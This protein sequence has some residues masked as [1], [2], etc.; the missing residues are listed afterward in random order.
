MKI[1]NSD[2]SGVEFERFVGD[3]SISCSHLKW[4]F[5]SFD[6]NLR[7]CIM[8]HI[9]ETPFKQNALIIFHRFHGGGIINPIQ[10]VK[11]LLL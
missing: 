11:D 2:D 5:F 4:F 7:P 9:S 6:F 1:P 8:T 3:M 10:K